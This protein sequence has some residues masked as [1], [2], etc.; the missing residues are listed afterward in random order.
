MITEV[1]KKQYEDF[2]TGITHPVRMVRTAWEQEGLGA[3]TI[4]EWLMKHGVH[5]GDADPLV[6]RLWLHVMKTG[7]PVRLMTT[8][9]LHKFSP[10]LNRHVIWD[11]VNPQKI[12]EGKKSPGS[13]SPKE[14]AKF[15][16]KEEKWLKTAYKDL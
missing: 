12:I 9:E 6:R 15:I 11:C 10:L 13:T 4:K 1:T 8:K 2:F 5:R 7:K 3:T 14:V 16:K